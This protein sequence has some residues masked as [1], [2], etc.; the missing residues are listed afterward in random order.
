[1]LRRNIFEGLVYQAR[2]SPHRSPLTEPDN[3]SPSLPARKPPA[4]KTARVQHDDTGVSHDLMVDYEIS[5]ISVFERQVFRL[6]MAA[7]LY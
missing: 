2:K 1:M 7:L 6:V 3:S 4:D 5:V